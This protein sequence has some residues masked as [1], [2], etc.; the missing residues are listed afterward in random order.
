MPEVVMSQNSSME[1]YQHVTAQS[2]LISQ[3]AGL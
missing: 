2:D 1:G 3:S